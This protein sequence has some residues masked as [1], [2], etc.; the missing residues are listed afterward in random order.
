[1]KRALA[2]LLLLAALAAAAQA[3]VQPK[4]ATEPAPKISA[5]A[6][7]EQDRALERR[8]RGIFSEIEG[9]EG[10][11]VEVRQ[12][13]VRLGGEV[14]SPG[15]RE[16]AA[17]LA[18]QVEGVVEVDDETTL[19]TDF[20][21]RLDAAL[22]QLNELLLGILGYL[23]LMAVALGVF[24]LFL[25]LAALLGRWERLYRRFAAND[26]L[27]DFLRRLVKLVVIV[28]GL[29]VAFELLDA[30][31]LLGG[32]LGAAGLVGIALG[33]ALRATVE[34]Y[35]A[36]I[37]LSTRQPFVHNDWV[38]I[39]GYEGRVIRLTSRATI[40]MTLDGNHVRIPNATVFNSVVIN[41]TR[42]P[43]RRFQFDV[44]VRTSEN[45]SAAQKLAAETLAAMEGVMDEPPPHVDVHEFGP[46]S[47]VLRAYGWVDQRHFEF[48]KVRSEAIRLVKEAFEAGGV[49]IPDPAYTLTM[50]PAAERREAA[51]AGPRRAIDIA[52]R[53]DLEQQIAEERAAGEP[54]LLRE[55]A[56]RE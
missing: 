4:P 52:R 33:F 18:R 44:G 10:I 27:V 5:V 8:L 2:S 14:L 20:R 48:L 22:D 49:E 53:S 17:K 7:P 21:R 56:P 31:A 30:T 50:A 39:N 37:L 12:G 54:D 11:T 47:L 40:I 41:Y 51:A 45:V 24:L 6:T 34:N 55:E 28:A 38:V 9:A 23:P 13:V 16:Q 42:N 35:I 29:L 26:F 1:M 3:P 32:V 25:A 46:S 36:G 19:V 15:A 43:Q